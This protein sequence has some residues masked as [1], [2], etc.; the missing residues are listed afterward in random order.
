MEVHV[1]SGGFSLKFSSQLYMAFF[2]LLFFFVLI[3]C[4]LKALFPLHKFN[5]RVVHYLEN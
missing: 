2:Y 1:G 5:A 4:G 3:R